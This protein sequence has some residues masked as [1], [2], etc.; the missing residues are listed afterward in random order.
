MA[1]YACCCDRRHLHLCCCRASH[2]VDMLQR[3]YEEGGAE[4]IVHI[5]DISYANGREEV[6]SPAPGRSPVLRRARG[7]FPPLC[8]SCCLFIRAA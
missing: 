1:A 3:E 7:P 4:L 2:T 5:G 6:R 8:V